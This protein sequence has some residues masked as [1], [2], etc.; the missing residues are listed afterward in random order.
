MYC[1]IFGQDSIIRMA[2]LNQ[3]LE[4]S[5]YENHSSIVRAAMFH[6]N[7]SS[8]F[9]SAGGIEGIFFWTFQ[10]EKAAI[11]VQP[12]IDLIPQ[13]L[14]EEQ[15]DKIIPENS[16]S[17]S[18]SLAEALH[19]EQEE[20][21]PYELQN[22]PRNIKRK[23][24]NLPQKHYVCSHDEKAL[25][26]DDISTRI[27]A[28][29]D[30]QINPQLIM[31]FNG[32]AHENIIWN[33]QANWIGYT[34]GNKLI[35]EDIRTR[36]QEIYIE[37]EA[38]I[39]TIALSSYKTFVATA[40]GIAN[41]SSNIADICIY[42]V[43]ESKPY[44]KFMKKL[45]FHEK[46]VQSLA[47]VGVKQENLCS[48][49]RFPECTLALWDIAKGTCIASEL[50]E[51]PT[52]FVEPSNILR[53]FSWTSVGKNIVT[54]WQ[55]NQAGLTSEKA[56]FKVEA[57]LKDYA[58]TSICQIETAESVV[59]LIGTTKG[60][61]VVYRPEKKEF[62]SEYPVAEGEISCIES[63][64]NTII[65]GAGKTLMKWQAESKKEISISILETKPIMIQLDSQIISMKIN[66]QANA[67]IA[68]T[69]SGTLYYVSWEKNFSARLQVGHSNSHVISACESMNPQLFITA[70]NDNAIRFYSKSEGDLIMEYYV[71]NCQCRKLII[72]Q[73]ICFGFFDD[74]VIRAF[75]LITL[76]QL[77][78]ISVGSIPLN[79][80][81][82][83]E[84]ILFVG[85]EE[86][87]CHLISIISLDPIAMM[88]QKVIINFK[89]LSCYN[90]ME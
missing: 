8:M 57:D 17:I 28:L 54:E 11:Q 12:D 64:N 83:S 4:I 46:G 73:K 49:G 82:A 85:D 79:S 1:G 40:T 27:C 67:T 52:N 9:I 74:G 58:F 84:N 47:F 86:G 41:K 33:E 61:I 50:L 66:E 29:T 23:E 48:I 63:K 75:S 81:V 88:S 87:A 37:Q 71:P 15:S 22:N 7:D 72:Y 26:Y 13:K 24:L 39:S 43:Q 16:I 6:P 90:L 42:T 59:G 5:E 31:G 80:A 34:I 77:G 76:K 30:S 78:K 65:I 44:I 19:F 60:T 69:A 21:A 10:G 3:H 51:V 53:N 45:S 14:L 36:Y 32:N 38:E 35:I 20:I 25:F 56:E 68:G 55:A 2:Q 62:L 89:S 18:P 70:T